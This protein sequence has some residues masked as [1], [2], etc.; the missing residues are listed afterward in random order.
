M[1]EVVLFSSGV[2]YFEHAGLVDGAAT[3]ELRVKTSQLNDLLKSLLLEDKDGGHPGAIEYPSLDP[4][5]KTLASFQV[6][7]SDN[8]TFA[9]LLGK[10]RG[11]GVSYQQDGQTVAGT[12]LGVESRTVAVGEHGDRTV[13]VPILNLLLGGTVSQVRLDQVANLTFTDKVLQDELTKALTALAQSRNQDKKPLVIHFDGQGQRHVS[14]A[15]VVETPVWKVSYRLVMPPAAAPA[16]D[17][18]AKP[19]VG[20]LQGWAIIENQTDS[21][22]D[23]VRLALV[24]GRPISFIEDLSQPLYVPR[25][26]VQPELYASLAPQTDE[27]GMAYDQKERLAVAEDAAAAPAAAAPMLGS[28]QMR[29]SGGR[30]R[31]YGQQEQAKSLK[32]RPGNGGVDI[33]RSIQ[34]AA[35]ADTLGQ[36]FSYTVPAVTLARQRSAMLPIITADVQVERVSIYNA[37]VLAAHP[38][39]GAL[40]TNTSGDLLLQGPVTVLDGGGYAGDASL[41]NLSQNDH[42]LLSYAI[43]LP[44]KVDGTTDTMENRIVSAIISQGVMTVEYRMTA[45]RMYHFE[46]SDE[47]ART[48]VLEHP[49]RQGWA[50]VDTAAPFERTD[51][52]DRWRVALPPHKPTVF[53]ITEEIVQGQ[54]IGIVQYGDEQLAVYLKD[55]AISQAVKDALAKVAALR[56]EV[57]EVQKVLTQASQ[58][59]NRIREDQSRVRENLKSVRE[60]G[61]Y[62]Q[63]LQAKLLAQENQVDALNKT[64]DE[65]RAALDLKQKA[66]NDFIAQ[67]SV[68]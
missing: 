41:D 7:I 59:Y 24:S 52:L 56:R 1:R 27:G 3:C 20:H 12:V 55:G 54:S 15:Y 37:S 4:I 66:L 9:Q 40:L 53:S 45:K 36:L 61:E 65:Q 64:I 28:A 43:D 29:A 33:T 2:G 58:D 42:R 26:V 16:A 50:L 47:Q 44:V 35:H 6:D 19:L 67:L 32:D 57:A 51:T 18:A 25:P 5:V 23:G 22:W 10:L 31:S 13:E 68:K 62:Y 49:F 39:N 30:A 48:V 46:A 17:A 21:D 38:L 11:A 14:L 60:N 8:P 34:S 63:R